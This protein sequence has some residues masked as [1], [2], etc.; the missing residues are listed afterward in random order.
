MGKQDLNPK[1]VMRRREKLPSKKGLAM[2][3]TRVLLVV[4]GKT[5]VCYFSHLNKLGIFQD[6]NFKTIKGDENDFQTIFKENHDLKH[7]YLILDID[8]C[9]ISNQKRGKKLET[10]FKEKY[11]KKVIYFNNYSFETFL[12]NHLQSF[13]KPIIHKHEYDIEMKRVFGV[14]S[15]SRSKNEENLCSV[16]N[17]IDTLQ[18]NQMLVNI[19]KI[20]DPNPFKNPNSSMHLLFEKLTEKQ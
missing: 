6:L 17:Q 8:N 16:L 5:E 7:K 9:P 2:L 3:S 14:D 20:Y 11:E 15:W 19:K 12:L 4:D 10:L 13:S 18:F 1:S